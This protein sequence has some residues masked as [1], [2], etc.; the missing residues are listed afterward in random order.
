MRCAKCKT[1][2]EDDPDRAS[3]KPCH[4][5]G[6]TERLYEKTMT[7]TVGTRSSIALKAK[8]PGERKPFMEQKS[9]DDLH[10]KTGKWSKLTRVINRRGDRYVE[11]IVDEET[12]EV[13]REVDEPLSKHR[14][15]GS[16][17]PKN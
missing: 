4:V 17:K 1:V 5:C 2:L 15:R 16:A 6:H 10:R 12:G 7:G 13:L 14:D 9:G 11:K 8:S 3:P